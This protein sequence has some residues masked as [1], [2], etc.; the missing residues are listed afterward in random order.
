MKKCFA[1]G[2]ILLVVAAISFGT[3]IPNGS[4]TVC[5]P[6]SP[7][8]C[9]FGA[10]NSIGLLSGDTQLDGWT[11]TSGGV[12][13][14]RSWDAGAG[15]NGWDTSA[16]SNGDGLANSVHLNTTTGGVPS[17]GAIAYDLSLAGLGLVDGGLYKIQFLMSGAPGGVKPLG[18]GGTYGYGQVFMN[19]QV[20]NGLPG[21]YAYSYQA[22]NSKTQMHWELDYYS[23]VYDS[24]VGNHTLTF[25]SATTGESFG[26]GID[27]IEVVD[28]TVPEPGTLSMLLGAG[29]LLG[30]FAL[31]RRSS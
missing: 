24:A 3:P 6:A 13:W 4:F 21:P 23:F 14:V 29:L 11:V 17:A 12:R 1:A 15:I 2:L 10:A 28:E 5:T 22:D 30:G 18:A 26:P 20:S 27:G 8:S 9:D 25:Q 16:T 7:G 19:V 31:K